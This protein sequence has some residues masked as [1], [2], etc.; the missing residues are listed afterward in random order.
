MKVLSAENNRTITAAEVEKWVGKSSKSK[1]GEV[2][3][4]EIAAGLTRFRWPN[5]PPKRFANEARVVDSD[6][7]PFWD[8]TA[9]TA[10][11]KTLL[12]NAP[13]MLS[14]WEGQRW[15]P[16]T[17]DGFDII[18]NLGDALLRAMPY[19]EWP[20][21]YYDGKTSNK[22]PK[23]WHAMA[24]VI[25]RLVIKSMI[26]A[27]QDQPGLARNSVVARI[28]YR[29]LFRMN[30][31][32]SNMITV[33]AIGAH[34]TRWDKKYGLT[35]SVIAAL[36]TKQTSGVCDHDLPH[37]AS[38]PLGTEIVAWRQ[39]WLRQKTKAQRRGRPRRKTR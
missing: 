1:M 20:L 14:H 31:P 11:A 9:V 5:D 4:H 27:G 28:V 18:K 8:F 34:L 33:T 3:F 36:T 24:I 37:V 7:S 10:A 32:N 21:G 16:Q 35:P 17:R 23:P 22:T 12:K 26:E 2:Q 38:Y 39:Q 25:A 29:A 15:A 19:I 13:A 30:F 6:G